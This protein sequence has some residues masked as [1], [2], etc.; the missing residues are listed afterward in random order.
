MAA[1]DSHDQDMLPYVPG[2]AKFFSHLRA[3]LSRSYVV[4]DRDW[5]TIAPMDFTL[6]VVPGDFPEACCRSRKL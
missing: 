6:I 3:L 5:R 1:S 2:A 4:V